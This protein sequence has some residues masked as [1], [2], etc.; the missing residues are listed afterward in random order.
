MASYNFMK[1]EDRERCRKDRQ[2]ELDAVENKRWPRDIND[3]M[4][5]LNCPVSEAAAQYAAK[6]CRYEIKWLDDIEH[7][8]S[9]NDPSLNGWEKE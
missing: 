5:W 2:E 4:R 3:T 1:R 9:M 6:M 7:R 8:L